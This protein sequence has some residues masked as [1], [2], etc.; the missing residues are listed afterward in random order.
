MK[1]YTF[2]SEYLDT[3]NFLKPDTLVKATFSLPAEGSYI[4]E[5]V[6]EDG[7]AHANIPLTRGRVWSIL[8]PL[9]DE[10]TRTIRKDKNTVMNATFRSI[11]TLRMK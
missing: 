6:R 4:L 2:A 5:I 8:D 1:R 3:E 9:T 11:N 10:Q 7:I